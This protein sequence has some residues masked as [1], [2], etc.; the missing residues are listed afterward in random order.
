ML[1]STAD[2][3]FWM[4][5]YIERAENT[6]RLI[7]TGLRMSLV[8]SDR[9]ANEWSA[10]LASA[11]I[12]LPDTE[13]RAVIELLL[14]DRDHPSSIA[15]CIAAGRTNARRVR[16]AVTR[17]V[18][19]AVNDFHLE[20]KAML[21]EPVGQRDLPDVLE[22][23][24]RAG[25]QVRG[26]LHG[27]MLRNDIYRFARLGTHLERADNTAR[28]LDVKYHV[29]LPREAEV[30]GPLD[31]AQWEQLLRSVHVNRAYM[32]THGTEYAARPVADFLILDRRMPRSLAFCAGQ[33]AEN[34][35]RL[36]EAGE[37]GERAEALSSR[38][39]GLDVETIILDGLHE[40][41]Q[42]FLAENADVA[43]AVARNY[44]FV[45]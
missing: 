23:I 19:E 24:R 15:S 4:S 27:T 30:N 41:L 3:L 2:G 34:L 9:A 40:F 38:L 37:A 22:R 35:E 43:D 25:A 21:A 14:R 13:P 44:R 45:A 10:L 20:A 29:L 17:E 16:T 1:G 32:M 33:V 8:R 18:W 26:S 6:A 31:N 5:R 36:G 12:E 42:G 39:R 28:I 11:G 7:E